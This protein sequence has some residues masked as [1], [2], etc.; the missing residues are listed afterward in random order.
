MSKEWDKTLG[1][2][3]KIA[4]GMLGFTVGGAVPAVISDL[5]SNARVRNVGQYAILPAAAVGS[6]AGWK[7]GKKYHEKKSDLKADLEKYEQLSPQDREK[8]RQMKDSEKLLRFGT[9]R[10]YF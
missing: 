6:Y 4:G 1:R 10:L 3:R 7:A 8:Y 9:G 2:D 5:S